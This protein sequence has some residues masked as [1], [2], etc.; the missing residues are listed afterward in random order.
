MP[1][2]EIHRADDEATSHIKTPQMME[3]LDGAPWDTVHIVYLYASWQH[4]AGDCML[5]LEHP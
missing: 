1:K 2:H 4:L 3:P 5:E